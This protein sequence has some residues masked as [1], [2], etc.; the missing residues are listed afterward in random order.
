MFSTFDFERRERER[1]DI[2]VR[3]LV[4]ICSCFIVYIRHGNTDEDAAYSKYQVKFEEL[5]EFDDDDEDKEVITEDVAN[6]ILDDLGPD[7][8]DV[9][10]HLIP[11]VCQQS[12]IRV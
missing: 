3:L 12:A 7:G 1:E 10:I 2:S 6:M 8:D 5:P 9:R 11:P 4:S